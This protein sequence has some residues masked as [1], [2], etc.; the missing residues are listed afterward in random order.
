MCNYKS[1][2]FLYEGQWVT[3][4][5]C[6]EPALEGDPDGLCIF[7]SKLDWKK[8]P[9]F[10]EK[11]TEYNSKQ[12]RKIRL[13]GDRGRV[14]NPVAPIYNYIGFSFP[15]GANFF[16]QEFEEAVFFSLATFENRSYFKGATFKGYSNFCGATFGERSNFE[17]TTFWGKVS[18]SDAE[19]GNSSD[20]RKATFYNEVDFSD[21]NIGDFTSFRYVDFC[22]DT[23]FFD[24]EFGEDVDFYESFFGGEVSFLG[25][26]FGDNISLEGVVFAGKVDFAEGNLNCANLSG[27]NLSKANLKGVVLKDSKVHRVKYEKKTLKAMDNMPCRGINA[28]TCYG[29][30][31]FKRFVEDQD[32]LEHLRYS[33]GTKSRKNVW[34]W[35]WWFLCDCGRSTWRWILWSLFF[36][37]FFA[38]Q[39]WILGPNQ[40]EFSNFDHFQHGQNPLTYLYYSIVTFTTLGF[41]D[42]TPKTLVAAYWVAAEVIVGYVMLGGLISIM[43]NKIARRS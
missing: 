1:I 37:F 9:D 35:L 14:L 43:A 33:D 13:F 4:E 28:S 15:E 18:F 26:T 31:E 29:D 24:V 34:F 23:D 19:I 27:A 6:Q 17:K 42:I 32:Y 39:F 38:F 5:E 30:P 12:P 41:G 25:V 22:K 21:A 11:L 7:H 3:F 10:H 20:F 8:K 40:F 2:G 16:G 36:A